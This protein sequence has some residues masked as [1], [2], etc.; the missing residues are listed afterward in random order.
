MA[1]KYNLHLKG[2]VG[3]WNFDRDYVDYILDR[4]ADKP[5]AVLIDSLGGQLDQ[6]L[7]I[8]AAFRNHGDVT[9]HYVGMNASAATVASMGAKHVTMDAA[10]MYLVHQCSL[11]FFEWGSMNA[12]QMAEL[13]EKCKGT[14]A[15][16][17]KFDLTIASLYAA[18][19][20]KD[21]KQLLALMKVGGWLT[22]KEA[23][24]WGFVDEITDEAEDAAPSLTEDVVTAMVA[25][26]IPVPKGMGADSGTSLL[27]KLAASLAAVFSQ[28]SQSIQNTMS[29]V[30]ARI[31][32]ALAVESLT[33]SADGKFTLT[34]E[35]L[36]TLENLVAERDEKISALESTVKKHES[37]IAERDSTIASL[38]DKPAAT[39]KAVV[40]SKPAAAAEGEKSQFEQFHDSVNNAREI[41]NNL[42]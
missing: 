14:V 26:G 21:V 25:H 30:F 40:E 12:T 15:D 18:K 23:L 38:R 3:G 6:A 33:A 24:E 16:L 29:K 42:P 32:G 35:Q 34:E 22:A 36:Q 37:T 1:K 31:C 4:N 7:S 19:C 5:V 27:K 11:S 9:V 10:A 20:K 17:E 13:I 2:Y 39:A 41:F 28:K 8:C